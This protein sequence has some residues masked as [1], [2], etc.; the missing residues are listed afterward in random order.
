MLYGNI[1]KYNL[2]VA[3]KHEYC[4]FGRETDEICDLQWLKRESWPGRKERNG[5]PLSAIDL[6]CGCGGLALGV[7]EAARIH[8]RSLQIQLAV[9]CSPNAIAVYRTNF[10]LDDSVA[11]NTDICSVFPG[12][13][14]EP[15]RQEESCIKARIRNSDLL[16]AGPPCQ[17]HSDLNN[18]TRRDDP[19]NGLYLKA[20]RAAE[21][22]N[23]RAILIENVP[24]VVHDKSACIR[25]SADMLETLSYNTSFF[26]MDACRVGLA[27]RRKRHFLL[28]VKGCG[29]DFVPYFDGLALKNRTLSDYIGDLEDE[30]K[31]KRGVFYVP[32]AMRGDNINRVEH[33]FENDVYDL[34]NE[35]RP[36][37]HRK[38]HSYV[39]MYGRMRWDE[40]AQTITS[41][42][43]SMGQGRFVHPSRKRTI[44]PHEAARIQ[45]FPDFF[46]FSG[47]AKRTA[48]Q[49]MIG[50]A[51]PPKMSAIVADILLKENII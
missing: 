38:N 24:G 21:L 20:I 1:E 45:G 23:P 9:D 8:C 25:K 41:G 43:G 50:N 31:V 15:E 27:Q 35:F 51:V 22:L 17:G 36:L 32:S 2:E 13:F 18:H 30:S 4:G 7:W 19:R 11:A 16:I 29:K 14:G 5:K 26:E 37:C 12:Q 48:L 3:D 42:F 44:T 33:L 6:F 46:D 49:E 34:P 47:V 10:G 40:P 28:A 39:S